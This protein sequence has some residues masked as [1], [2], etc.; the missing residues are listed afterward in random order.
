[1]PPRSRH[2]STHAHCLESLPSCDPTDVRCAGRARH[3]SA[4]VDSSGHFPAR[5]LLTRP[6]P[7]LRLTS[8]A[9]LPGPGAGL[10]QHHRDSLHTVHLQGIICANADP[11]IKNAGSGW[12]RSRFRSTFKNAGHGHKTLR[13]CRY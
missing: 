13:R 2:R 10:C 12:N 4:R 1:M 7:C 3:S 6:T 5:H 9:L 11:D 8:S